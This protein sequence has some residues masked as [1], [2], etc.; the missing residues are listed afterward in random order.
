MASHKQR[1][2]GKTRK[3]QFGAIALFAA[4]AAIAALPIASL[5][6]PAP[7]AKPADQEVVQ[8]AAPG[9]ELNHDEATQMALRMADLGGRVDV[10]APP[11]AVDDPK[12]NEAPP[13]AEPPPAAATEWTYAGYLGGPTSKMAVVKYNGSQTLMSVGQKLENSEFVEIHPDHVIV[14]DAG[15]ERRVDIE[16]RTIYF[17][18][19]GSAR[20]IAARGPAPGQPGFGRPGQPG[21][22]GFDRNN[23]AA[24]NAAALA[25]AQRRARAAMTPPA[26]PPAT[27]TTVDEGLAKAKELFDGMSD[28]ERSEV[29]KSVQDS[30]GDVST[31]L[32]VLR[33]LGLPTGGDADARVRFLNNLGITPETDPKLYESVKSMEKGEQ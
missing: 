18:T 27:I 30:S 11:V 31:R 26:I 25:E 32:D 1:A 16:K 5:L 20:P 28:E 3:W 4:A 8:V 2:R 29:M 24:N 21:G 13:S 14:S 9:A 15:V 17:P 19:G 10:I 7:F 6:G 22:P 33:N 23:F 12:V